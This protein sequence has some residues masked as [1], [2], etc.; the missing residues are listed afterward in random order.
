MADPAAIFRLVNERND[1]PGGARRCP[2]SP[3]GSAPFPGPEWEDEDDMST[4]WDEDWAWDDMDDL[5]SDE[6]F[7]IPQPKE[8]AVPVCCEDNEV[9]PKRRL[10]LLRGCPH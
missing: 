5:W 4:E 1:L 2:P 9:V 3:E 8:I 6:I 7:P 10:E